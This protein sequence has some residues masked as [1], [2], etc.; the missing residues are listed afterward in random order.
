MMQCMS[1]CSG[2]AQSPT[3]QTCAQTQCQA[4]VL[5]CLNDT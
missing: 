1:E 5:A 4:Q 3:C 2:G